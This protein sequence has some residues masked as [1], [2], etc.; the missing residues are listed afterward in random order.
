MWLFRDLQMERGRLSPGPKVAAGPLLRLPFISGPVGPLAAR[1]GA[2]R[3]SAHPGLAEKR[4]AESC[5]LLP[6]PPGA[7]RGF[8]LE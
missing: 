5:P 3:M 4:A 2:G 8:R 7:E 1:E 6:E